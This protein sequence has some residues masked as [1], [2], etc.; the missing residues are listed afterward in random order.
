MLE[1]Y[2]GVKALRRRAFTPKQ[3]SPQKRNAI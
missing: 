3:N 2:L 1:H